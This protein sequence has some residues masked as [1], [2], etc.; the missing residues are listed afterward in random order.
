M[1]GHS[2]HEERT[3]DRQTISA[4]HG[5]TGAALW[6]GAVLA[7]TAREGRSAQIEGSQNMSVNQVDMT[8]ELTVAKAN[9]RRK[10]AMTQVERPFDN[11]AV[12]VDLPTLGLRLENEGS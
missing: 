1:R 3:L 8:S 10:P 6:V 12:N 5:L 11:G 7:M 9:G 4:E 2:T